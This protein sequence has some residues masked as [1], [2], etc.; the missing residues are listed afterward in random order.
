MTDASGAYGLS[1]LYRL[2]ECI[3]WFL[4]AIAPDWQE[5]V[6]ADYQRHHRRQQW[7]G[8]IAW[9]WYPNKPVIYEWGWVNS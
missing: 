6:W 9:F 2:Q 3:R 5:Q 8:S 4:P 7:L 1:L